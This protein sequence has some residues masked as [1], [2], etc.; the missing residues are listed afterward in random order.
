MMQNLLNSL[1]YLK[2][3]YISEAVITE[4]TYLSAKHALICQSVGLVPIVD[5]L[6]YGNHYCIKHQFYIL[7]E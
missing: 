4:N 1:L 3:G 5:L 2:N 7:S 6:M